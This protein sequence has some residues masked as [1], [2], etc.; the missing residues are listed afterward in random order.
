MIKKIFLVIFLL[1]LGGVVYLASFIIHIPLISN[2]TGAS[3]LQNLGVSRD[4][5]KLRSVL[6]EN[7]FDVQTPVGGFCALCSGTNKHTGKL[8]VDATAD[9][10][11]L[12]TLIS[13][14]QTDENILR[15]AQVR[16]ENGKAKILVKPGQYLNV[17]ILATGSVTKSG[18]KSVDISLED[19]RIGPAGVPEEYIAE[20]EAFLEEAINDKLAKWENVKIEE[21]R[22]VGDQLY[23][24]GD[25]PKT[26]AAD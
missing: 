7:N 22:I 25:L 26:H 3:D 15:N 23:F 20:A 4:E 9:S 10:V 24:K 21:L 19:V 17:P 2:L 13:A 11:D 16:L 5:A 1:I 8:S 14:N 12:T 18:P 6:A